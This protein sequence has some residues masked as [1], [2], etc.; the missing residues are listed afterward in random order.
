MTKKNI[1]QLCALYLAGADYREEGA[2]FSVESFWSLRGFGF[3]IFTEFGAYDIHHKDLYIEPMGDAEEMT[4]AD[5]LD[6]V[7][8]YTGLTVADLEP[9]ELQPADA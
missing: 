7:Q 2:E 4:D 6:L 8:Q 1:L 5:L 3:R 9:V